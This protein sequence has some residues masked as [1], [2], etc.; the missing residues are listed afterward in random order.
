MNLGENGMDD[1]RYLGGGDVSTL[2]PFLFL[3][4]QILENM[5]REL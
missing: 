5:R 2:I 1:R 3:E 4:K